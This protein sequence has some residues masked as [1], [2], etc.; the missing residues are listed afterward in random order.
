MTERRRHHPRRRGRPPRRG[1][2]SPTTSPP[3]ATSCSSP[4]TPATA[5]RLLETQFPD[6]ALVDLGLPDASGS[7]CCAQVREADGVASRIDPRLPLLVLTGRVGELDRVRGFERGRRR[8]VVQAVLL[9]G[10]A[11]PRRGAAA[12]RASAA[13]RRA[14]ARRRARDRPAGARG[15][16]ARRAASRSRRR[17]SRCCARSPAEPT[18]VFTKEELL[19]DV[20]GFRAMG[21]TRTLDSHACRLRQ[22]L[23]RRRR[24][25]R[26]Q[27]VGRRLPARRRR[28]WSTPSSGR[29]GADVVRRRRRRIA[30]ARRR[31]AWRVVLR[32]ARWSSSRA[33]ATSCAGR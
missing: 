19:R 21:S 10:A 14:A 26:R 31:A 32:A 25:L 17:S 3:T 27:R 8:L 28:R 13:A 1:R 29:R 22:K 4:T 5:L 16:A 23:A 2:S 24:P 7:S 15:A 33:P 30:R 12:P 18:R 6:L 9:P 11:R 20:W